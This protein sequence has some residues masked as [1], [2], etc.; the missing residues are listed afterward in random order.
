MF[1]KGKGG[2]GDFFRHVFASGV[3][4]EFFLPIN[5]ALPWP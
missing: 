1:L 2:G 4:G 5:F 3:G